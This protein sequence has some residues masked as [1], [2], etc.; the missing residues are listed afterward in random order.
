MNAGP[1]RA[2]PRRTA[3]VTRY[4]TYG[5]FKGERYPYRRPFWRKHNPL[6]ALTQF[7]LKGG[8]FRDHV[9][10]MC[11]SYDEVDWAETEVRYF[12]HDRTGRM[13]SPSRGG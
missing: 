4:Y 8:R 11:D 12:E 7:S 10:P 1:Y 13:K 2:C 3:R 9:R 5:I 6:Q